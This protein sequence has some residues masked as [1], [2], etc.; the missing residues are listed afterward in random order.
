MA[1]KKFSNWAK[2]FG[3]STKYAAAN[4]ADSIAPNTVKAI[5][6][7]KM[8]ASDLRSSMRSAKSSVNQLTTD[9]TKTKL[10][11]RADK[12]YKAAVKAI[13]S[14]NFAVKNSSRPKKPSGSTISGLDGLDKLYDFNDND[15]FG[16]GDATVISPNINIEMNNDAT[17]EALRLNGQMQSKITMQSAN[18]VADAVNNTMLSGFIKVNEQLITTNTYLQ[19]IDSNIQSIIEFNNDSVAATN[20]AM[21]DFMTKMDEY[22]D[23]IRDSRDAAKRAKEPTDFYDKRNRM[24]QNLFINGSGIADYTKFVKGNINSK[25]S[26]I[27]DMMNIFGPDLGLGGKDDVPL[28]EQLF[29]KALTNILIPPGVQKNFQ[30]L[31]KAIP[32]MIRTSL[33]KVGEKNGLLSGLLGLN[34][35]FGIRYD[36]IKNVDLSGYHKGEIPWDGEAK[37]A[38]TT[39]IPTQLNQIIRLL[40]PANAGANQKIFDYEKG[41]FYNQNELEAKYR[42]SIEDQVKLATTGIGDALS[43]SITDMLGGIGDDDELKKQIRDEMLEAIGDVF[44]T[45]VQS[46]NK[47]GGKSVDYRNAGQVHQILSG[48]H[49]QETIDRVISLLSSLD[50]T[51]V[52]TLKNSKIEV[53]N[54][55]NEISDNASK[56][57][58]E[59]GVFSNLAINGEDS[60]KQMMKILNSLTDVFDTGGDSEYMKSVRNY[61]KSGMSREEAIEQA[62]KKKQIKDKTK[63]KIEELGLGDIFNSDHN[64]DYSRSKNPFYRIFDKINKGANAAESAVSD[65]IYGD[66]SSVV[67]KLFVKASNFRNK[68]VRLDP[69][70]TRNFINADDFGHY[71]LNENT[72]GKSTEDILRSIDPSNSEGNPLQSIGNSFKGLVYGLYSTFLRPTYD[73]VFGEDGVISKLYNSDKFKEVRQ[74]VT[75]FLIGEKGE[76]RVYKDGVF[77]GIANVFSDGVDYLKYSFTG[78][79]Y[80]SRDGKT[81]A[82]DPDNSVVGK[83]SAGLGKAYTYMMEYL[84]GDKSGEEGS[85]KDNP[86]YQNTFGKL[87]SVIS[88]LKNKYR[89]IEYKDADQAGDLTEVENLSGS[90]PEEKASIS[91]MSPTAAKALLR[92]QRAGLEISAEELKS[93]QESIKHTP[94]IADRLEEFVFGDPETDDEQ[95][96]KSIL[97]SM[98][99]A[100]PTIGLGATVG[101][102]LA[103]SS[104]GNMGLLLGAFLPGGPIGG[105]IVGAAG[106][107]LL[108]NEKFQ[109]LMFGDMDENGQRQGGIISKSL[110]DKFKGMLPVIIGGGAVGALKSLAFGNGLAGSA[111][112]LGSTFLPGGPLGGAVLSVAGAMLWRSEKFQ[113]LMFGDVDEDGKRSGT[114]FSNAINNMGAFL[115]KNVNFVKGGIKGAALG[116]VTAGVVGQMGYL[117]AM[118]TPAGPIGG[119]VLGLGLGI[120][121]QTDKFKNLLFGDEEVDEE[122]NVTGRAKNGLIHRFFNKLEV[123]VFTPATNNMKY[124]MEDASYF[125]R[126]NVVSQFKSIAGPI[127][128]SFKN[129]KDTVDRGMENM[130]HTISEGVTSVFKK[131]FEPVTNMAT[132]MFK[133]VTGS[134]FNF[135]KIAGNLGGQL[136]T[137]PLK[138]MAGASRS[139][140]GGK[141]EKA[142]RKE[143]KGKR[144]TAIKDS[145]LGNEEGLLAGIMDTYFGEKDEETGKRGKSRFF[146]F[147]N[148]YY[149]DERENF[150]ERE[151]LTT[152]DWF[153]EPVKRKQIK[154][155]WK[156][157]QKE[158]RQEQELLKIRQK[159]QKEDKN[160]AH[161]DMRDPE[162]QYRLD[163]LR[164]AGMDISDIKSVKD[165][166]K[167]TYENK[168]FMESRNAAEKTEA[169]QTTV[170]DNT[171]KA[172]DLLDQGLTVDM[173]ILNQVKRITDQPIDPSSLK[174]EHREFANAD[175]KFDADNV[176]DKEAAERTEAGVLG[177]VEALNAQKAEEE[178]RA[179][180]E[181]LAFTAKEEADAEKIAADAAS[182]KDT[183]STKKSGILG[184]LGNITGALGGLKTLLPGVIGAGVLAAMSNPDTAK[185][186]IGWL[187][188]GAKAVASGVSGAIKNLII[189][190]RTNADGEFV[191]YSSLTETSVASAAAKAAASGKLIPQLKTSGALIKA[192]AKSAYSIG[193]HTPILGGMVK[194]AGGVAKAGGE[195]A[196]FATDAIKDAKFFKAGDNTRIV[197]T[198]ARNSA[199]QFLAKAKQVMAEAMTDSKITKLISNSKVLSGIT[200]FITTTISKLISSGD[201]AVR[202]LAEVIQQKGRKL[203]VSGVEAIPYVGWVIAA[204]TGIWDAATGAMEAANL[205]GVAEEDVDSL[206][207][208]VSSV[209]KVLIGLSLPGAVLDVIA[210]TIS[211]CMGYDWKQ[212]LASKIYQL[213]ADATTGNTEKSDSL[214]QKQNEFDAAYNAYLSQNA[215]KGVNISK[216]AYTDMQN[217]TTWTKL[218]NKVSN[219]NPFKKSSGNVGSGVNLG[220]G[221][222]IGSAIGYGYSQNDGRWKDTIIGRNPDGTVSTMGSG[223]C[224]PTALAAAYA[225]ATGKEISPA[226][227]GKMASA[228][229]Y[230]SNGGANAKLFTQGAKDLGISSRRLNAMEIEAQVKAGNPVVISGKS[231]DGKSLY[232]KVGHILTVKGVD[233]NGNATVIDPQDGQTKVRSMASLLKGLTHAWAIGGTKGLSMAS[234]APYQLPVNPL[235][236]TSIGSMK[237]N[238]LTSISG[239]PIERAPKSGDM[240][241][242]K[243]IS[244]SDGSSWDAYNGTIYYKQYDSRWKK[245]PYGSS[246]IGKIGCVMS[247]LAMALSGMT[248]QAITPA[249][250]VERW[251]NK[252]WVNG[253]GTSWSI[254]GD[255]AKELGLK[256][257]QVDTAGAKAALEAGKPVLLFGQKTGGVYGSNGGTHAV[258]ATGVKDNGNI[259]IND[260]G[261]EANTKTK[262]LSSGVPFASITNG[263]KRGYAFSTA[264]GGGLSAPSGYSIVDSST[265]GTFG[266]SISNSLSTAG[267]YASTLLSD[268]SNKIKPFAAILTSA[269][270][271]IFSGTGYKSVFDANGNLIGAE[272]ANGISTVSGDGS[273]AGVASMYNG[274]AGKSGMWPGFGKLSAKFESS[275]N[276]ATVV[277]D[278]IG[279]AFGKHQWNSTSGLQSFMSMMKSEYPDMYNKYFAN[280]PIGNPLNPNESFKQAWKAAATGPDA[281]KFD[282]INEYL[283]YKKYYANGIGPKAEQIYGVSMDSLKYPYAVKEALVSTAVQHGVGGATKILKKI[284]SVTPEREFLQDLYAKRTQA[285]PSTTKRYTNEL[286]SALELVDN[287][288]GYGK[289]SKELDRILKISNLQAEGYGNN[290]IGG[291]IKDT[292]DFMEDL[293]R[294]GRD[295]YERYD[296]ET[297]GFGDMIPQSDDIVGRM[298]FG[299]L[300]SATKGSSSGVEEKLERLIKIMSEKSFSN[301]INIDKHNDIKMVGKGG[302]KTNVNQKPVIVNKTST[303]KESKLLKKYE[304]VARRA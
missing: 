57:I 174:G 11:Q 1:S 213:I 215:D 287:A 300:I 125:I 129:V 58:G 90:T 302:N 187:G 225:L 265:T 52:A 80:I 199:Q 33:M 195:L 245:T 224:G 59:E 6:D 38:L 198:A 171:T 123:D 251:G 100:L 220:S 240:F 254:M 56:G 260:P 170:S 32:N 30:R 197:M 23:E 182:G 61:M 10:G 228:N 105:A 157:T 78:K 229:G 91:K 278:N 111:G 67:E 181:G 29:T 14:G 239:G 70:R 160:Y 150:A 192:T 15:I 236:N 47:K 16:G 299:E 206:M 136:L 50:G 242:S 13:K 77:S 107:L 130:F 291:D 212:A 65:L 118:L 185:N 210:T 121:S 114:A 112:I 93:A 68:G 83:L 42:K 268:L 115:K 221:S 201:G 247:S 180:A 258:L 75:K 211:A 140:F 49:D 232:S 207:R 82:D 204:G 74:K 20:M 271:G 191:D 86:M 200:E 164:R 249:T 36:G 248:G 89:K 183:T 110:Q 216:D 53:L 64:K 184:W 143:Y 193:S 189:E 113:K 40:D 275:G 243:T 108:K 84:F 88:D 17:L 151:N 51:K 79:G 273:L 34:E 69:E 282:E 264:N 203:V 267:N 159:F 147:D 168:D 290:I 117:G 71:N 146:G 81:Y 266:D 5:P 274:T 241:D 26:T 250:V 87:E 292:D 208:V 277:K 270:N 244:L 154:K 54:N 283:I 99:E 288:V 257:T 262:W 172:I 141:Q 104:G 48:K 175:G 295:S 217:P 7:I 219:L 230:I 21:M 18:Y 145:I 285:N 124:M 46:K 98:K 173:D 25:V 3:K 95:K 9:L 31:D 142:F 259:R 233:D 194:A 39:V 177:A 303:P 128:D 252:Y 62:K 139:I 103:L 297:V 2:N 261:S 214:T 167:W 158:R 66:K 218:K 293:I 120:A 298:P 190:N 296:F 45:D 272:T 133:A 226:D 122:G 222:G 237:N 186:V 44:I 131:A 94:N 106:G 223:G 188:E 60:S 72:I 148:D 255:A 144:R 138:L 263:F 234:G 19:N 119:A 135:T 152:L 101:A 24:G 137:S 276:N 227:V 269:I 85:Y 253:A 155:Q 134:V 153:M 166:N 132:K 8:A 102:G 73:K 279:W 280:A 246:N 304:L 63:G 205:F 286:A 4:I 28:I 169:Y 301:T 96:K 76:D 163:V 161:D 231:G 162:F 127:V 27:K 294:G 116:G 92:R 179:K 55:L 165:L 12:E 176:I 43:D 196:K 284:P 41:I 97:K 238:L 256:A 202:T 235:A 289:G 149:V 109:K 209:I 37:K 178:R 22:I 126:L 156:E 35:I 281:A